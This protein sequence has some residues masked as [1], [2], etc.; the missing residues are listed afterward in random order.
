MRNDRSM[1]S[2]ESPIFVLTHLQ[3]GGEDSFLKLKRK[4]WC[5]WTFLVNGEWSQTPM[6][7]GKT[8][9]YISHTKD[10]LHWA[11]LDEGFP[12]RIVAVARLTE[13]LPV[14][15]IAA[16]MMHRLASQGGKYIEFPYDYGDIDSEKLWS[17]FRALQDA[18]KARRKTTNSEPIIERS[19]ETTF[20][21]SGF[22][23][24][25]KIARRNV[26]AKK[27]QTY[28]PVKGDRKKY[29]KVRPL[30]EDLRSAYKDDSAKW[31]QVGSFLVKPGHSIYVIT[32]NSMGYSTY[33]DTIWKDAVAQLRLDGIRVIATTESY[34]AGTARIPYFAGMAR[35]HVSGWHQNRSLIRAINAAD[36]NEVDSVRQEYIIWLR[37]GGTIGGSE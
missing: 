23:A 35:K 1:K 37:R 31:F 18:E 17:M 27:R 29:T 7:Q 9:F 15:E 24:R 21:R 28:R 20:A 19:A 32:A 33:S 16:L 8:S 2:K 3:A 13:I 22:A 14:E 25:N 34:P 36:Q 11:L 30:V 26:G 6:N 10:K 5:G 4:K 12:R